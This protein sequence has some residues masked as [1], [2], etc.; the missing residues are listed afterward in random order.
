MDDTPNFSASSG[1]MDTDIETAT[2][3]MLWLEMTGSPTGGNGSFT[4]APIT[5]RSVATRSA[6][7]P[8]TSATSVSGTGLLDVIGGAVASY[9]DTDIFGC[10][11][12]DGPNCPDTADKLFASIGVL[13]PQGGTWAFQGT[14]DVRDAGKRSGGAARSAEDGEAAQP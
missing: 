12:G 3:G 8:F 11:E 13:S 7:D 14:G 2:D 9:F 1:D 4:G 10:S 5:L 6:G